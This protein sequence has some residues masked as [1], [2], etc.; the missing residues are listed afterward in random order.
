[1]QRKTHLKLRAGRI[2]FPKKVIDDLGWNDLGYHSSANGSDVR[3][4]NIDALARSAHY[5]PAK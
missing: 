4:P 3:S 5:W 1:M 2:V